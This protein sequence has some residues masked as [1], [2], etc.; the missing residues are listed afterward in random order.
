[1]SKRTIYQCDWCGIEAERERKLSVDAVARA[2][3][4]GRLPDGWRHRATD[5]ER[6]TRDAVRFTTAPAIIEIICGGCVEALDEAIAAVK[7][8]RSSRPLP[9]KGKKTP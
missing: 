2:R 5:G 3:R 8:H 1:M 7:K 4:H 6:E 9:T